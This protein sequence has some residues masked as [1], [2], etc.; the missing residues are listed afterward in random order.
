MRWLKKLQVPRSEVAAKWN[1]LRY[2][3][4]AVLKRK[5]FSKSG[6]AAGTAT[7][8]S[9]LYNSLNFLERTLRVEASTTS[10]LINNSPSTL[11]PS[12]LLLESDDLSGEIQGTPST[13]RDGFG[14]RRNQEDDEAYIE[15]VEGA[16]EILKSATQNDAWDG[17]ENFV[18]SNAREWAQELPQGAKDFKRELIFKYQQK[19]AS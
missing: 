2:S 14:R 16:L 9:P 13:S 4:R 18:A 11:I 1:S 12:P 7:T 19:V 5:A 8:M 17:L 15:V 3:I 6:Q 10:N